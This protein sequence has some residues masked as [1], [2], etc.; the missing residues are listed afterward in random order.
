MKSRKLGWLIAFALVAMSAGTTFAASTD[1]AAD[2][3][4]A[5]KMM[6]KLGRGVVNVLTCWVE[7]PR[8]VAKEWEK[9]DP[10]SGTVLGTAEGF[11]W[12]FARFATGVYESFTFLLPVPADYQPM[13]LPEFVV[14]DI[15]GDP[16]P[17][18]DETSTARPS[19]STNLPSYPQ[20][21]NY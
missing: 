5:A 4:D 21:F 1:A 6:H 9:T 3:S 20:Q 16:I 13:M 10:F 15:W 18:F 12:G 14:T 17:G 7:I 2:Q 19:G 11:G 8:H